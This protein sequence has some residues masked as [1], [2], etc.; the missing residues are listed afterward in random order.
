MLL[1]GY[2]AHY[3]WVYGVRGYQNQ[4]R[5]NVISNANEGMRTTSYHALNRLSQAKLSPKV[6]RGMLFVSR[7]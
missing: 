3:V 1:L 2:L 5:A 7:F 6:P 4:D